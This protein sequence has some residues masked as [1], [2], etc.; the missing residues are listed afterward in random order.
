MQSHA[1][2]RD[3]NDGKRR[4]VEGGCLR[5]VSSDGKGLSVLDTKEG[6]CI[7]RVM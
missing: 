6:E 4:A 1:K 5:A 3:D 2:A 7:A